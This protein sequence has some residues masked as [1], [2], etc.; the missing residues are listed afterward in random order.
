MLTEAAVCSG[1]TDKPCSLRLIPCLPQQPLC[2][3]TNAAGLR[4]LPQA[5]DLGWLQTW[6]KYQW[7]FSVFRIS[8]QALSTLQD[9]GADARRDQVHTGLRAVTEETRPGTGR[10]QH[11]ENP[12]SDSRCFHGLD[13]SPLSYGACNPTVVTLPARGGVTRFLKMGSQDLKS[14]ALMST[15]T[16]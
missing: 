15:Y 8:H 14:G 13:L 6:R 11:G 2:L 12:A 9:L 5:L 4:P 3:R 7:L 16:H 10:S 1:E